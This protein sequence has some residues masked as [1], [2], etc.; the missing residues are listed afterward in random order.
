M[1]K[2]MED[3]E[4]VKD[5]IQTLGY[6]MLLGA[7]AKVMAPVVKAN[8]L[9]AVVIFSLIEMLLVMFVGIYSVYHV[10]PNIV[11]KSYP[12]FKLKGE[13]GFESQGIRTYIS[14]E[15]GYFCIVSLIFIIALA[16]VIELSIKSALM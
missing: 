2:I 15:F 13:D 10:C 14:Y 16:Q 9:T 5:I 11:R 12:S 8:G 1:R 6:Y 3:K 7:I 4:L